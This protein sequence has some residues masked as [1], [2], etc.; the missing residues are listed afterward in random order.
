MGL[1]AYYRVSTKKQGASGLGLESQRAII[2][3][4]HNC[5]TFV[6]E[7]TDVM[8]GKNADR[9]EL[10]KAIDL[11]VSEGH[12]LVVAKVDRLSRNTEDALI[13]YDK[14]DQ[15]LYCCDI[16]NLDKFTLTIFM[17]I[18]DRELELISIRTKAALAAKKAQ[19]VEL[20]KPENL[21]PEAQAMGSK[22]MAKQAK[23][24]Y[25]A[26]SNYIQMMRDRG[27]SFR[28]IADQL[29]TE[30]KTTRNGREFKAMTVKRI[31]DRI[32]V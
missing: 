24:A 22:A 18:A 12:H 10:Q 9:P 11:C 5:D 31:L 8:S 29:N 26:E 13:I 28:Q 2:C 3:H 20:G 7:F 17:A 27:W 19:G 1:V 15:R 6:A 30:G 21:T 4:Y 14:L 25:K 32:Q 23:K 16:P